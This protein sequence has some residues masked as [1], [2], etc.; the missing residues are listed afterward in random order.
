MGSVRD[1]HLFLWNVWGKYF[2]S[3]DVFIARFDW[4]LSSIPGIARHDGGERD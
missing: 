4:V 3:N 1:E 2:V